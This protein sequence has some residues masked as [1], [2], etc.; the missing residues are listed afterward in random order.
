MYCILH[1]C[2]GKGVV[3]FAQFAGS[4][5]ET[6]PQRRLLHLPSI[7]A[8]PHR[9]QTWNKILCKKEGTTCMVRI[10]VLGDVVIYAFD[11]V[12]GMHEA[13]D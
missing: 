3:P 4:D 10:A 13:K 1:T 2:H 9:E 5:N 7:T 11:G 12:E 8:T 6:Q